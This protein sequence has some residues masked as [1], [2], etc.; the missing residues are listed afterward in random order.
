M[1]SL[2]SSKH[3]L[4]TVGRF[5]LLTSILLLVLFGTQETAL[6]VADR[7]F[8]FKYVFP[9]LLILY[10]I[11]VLEKELRELD[12]F[13]AFHS[14]LK[15][16][17]L[18]R[19][20]YV[21]IPGLI[22]LL[23]SIGGAHFSCAAFPRDAMKNLTP[24][25]SASINFYFRH[26]HVY[27][28]PLIAGTV[29]A[30]SIT[31]TSLWTVS[32]TLLPLTLLTFYFGWKL[33]IP[34]SASNASVSIKIKNA[35]ALKRN[36]KLLCFTLAL[37][38][39]FSIALG[40]KPYFWLGLVILT[41]GFTKKIPLLKVIKPSKGTIFLLSEIFFILL[42][43]CVINALNVGSLFSNFIHSLGI[44]PLIALSLITI[45]LAYLTGISQAYIAIVMP[46][47]L[48]LPNGSVFI[49]CWLLALGFF[50]QFFTPAHLCLVV[51]ANFFQCPIIEILKKISQPL[52]IAFA[53]WSVV[54]TA[55]WSCFS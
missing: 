38:T 1:M 12:L 45:V 16:R 37:E 20:S 51:C 41:I 10:L 49:V 15:T 19:Q 9:P 48:S 29:L 33:L 53:V 39:L 2:K 36:D 26:F 11:A 8:S 18:L 34:Q 17:G 22:G 7:I 47:S 30:C 32:L 23:P 21:L 27:S 43:A 42:F 40:L 25:Q 55:F 14:Y 46:L 52:I 31:N 44:T 54:F 6:R 35:F 3:R 13:S 4:L 28:N 5:F 24:C 50:V